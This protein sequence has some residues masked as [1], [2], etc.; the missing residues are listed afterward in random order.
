MRRIGLLALLAAAVVVLIAACGAQESGGADTLD[1]EALVQERCA[2][3]HALSRVT[4]ARK[5]QAQWQQTVERM[6]AQGARLNPEEQE[7]VVEYLAE[8]YPAP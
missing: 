4:E 1:G 5:T 7:A 8:A 3:C 6:V 2:D